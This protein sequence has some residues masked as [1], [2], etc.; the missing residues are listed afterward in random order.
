MKCERCD[1][2]KHIV[3]VVQRFANDN[4]PDAQTELWND[5]TLVCLNANC[6]DFGW[7]G[8]KPKNDA[9][10]PKFEDV[11]IT[12]PHTVRVI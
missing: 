11:V 10:R 4:T 1:Q 12:T 2:E 8:W 5:S 6:S 9:D 7:P 3:K